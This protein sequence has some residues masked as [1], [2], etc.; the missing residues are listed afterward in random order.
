MKRSAFLISVVVLASL[1]LAAPVLASTPPSNDT[2][3]TREVIAAVPFSATVD[4]TAA[5]TDADDLEALAACGAPAVD[6]TIWYSLT[7]A[8][9]GAI[10]IDPSASDYAAGVVVVSGTPGNFVFENCGTSVVLSSTAGFTYSI[11]I[12]DYDASGNCG[13][14]RHS[15]GDVPPPPVIDLTINPVASFNSR[16]GVATIRGTVTCS[17]GNPGGKN[18][19]E[20]GMTQTVGRLKLSADGFASFI[21]DGTVESW[22]ADMASPN[23]KFAGGKATVSAFAI[24]CSDFSCG[25]DDANRVVTLKK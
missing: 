9:D 18:I 1:T 13:T 17:G 11:L 22:A 10:L 4:T 25:D 3:A 15:D 21:C 7:A 24:A 16:T 6:A 23:G 2:Y 20:L 8:A 19:I 14:H 12:L 5:T